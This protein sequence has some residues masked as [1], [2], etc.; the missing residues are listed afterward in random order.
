MPGKPTANQSMVCGV[1]RYRTYEN[2]V[3]LEKKRMA[4]REDHGPSCG[5]SATAADA[6]LQCCTGDYVESAETLKGGHPYNVSSVLT[7]EKGPPHHVEWVN[8]PRRP[9]QAAA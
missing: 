7:G 2:D 6:F 5:W 8:P 3:E 4:L 9:W 1:G